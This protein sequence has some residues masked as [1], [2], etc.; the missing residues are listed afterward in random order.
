ILNE[1]GRGG[2]GVVYLATRK[3]EEFRHQVAIKLVKRG[4]DTEDILRRFRNERQILASLNHPNIAKLFDGGMTTDGLPYFVMEYVEGLPLLQYCDDHNVSTHERLRL[5]RHV[6]AAVQ[7]AHQNLIIHRD[8]KP[9]NILTT[10]EGEVKLLDFGVAKLLS[11][12][13]PEGAPT[14]TQAALRVMTPEYAS[15]EQ[16]RGQHVTTATDVYSLGVVLYELLTGAKP[17]KLKDT[18]PGELSRAICDSEPSKPSEAV[19][20]PTS[21]SRYGTA[22]GSDR[23]P[24]SANLFDKARAGRYRSRFRNEKSPTK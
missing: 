4:L 19:R 24:V 7:H 6:C 10:S 14:Q 8:L 13:S 2:M 23:P 5:F 18:S 1:I 20:E 17:Y 12:G 15:P 22:S 16:V 9:T 11:P 3:D 21:V